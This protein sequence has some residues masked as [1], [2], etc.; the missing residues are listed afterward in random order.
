MSIH[1]VTITGGELL[2]DTGGAVG[3]Q[4]VLT[5][6]DCFLTANT[7][8]AGGAVRND[9]TMTI[10][11]TTVS[12]NSAVEYGGGIYNGG[13]ADLTVTGSTIVDNSA[14]QGA[15]LFNFVAGVLD[16][17][18]STIADND[19]SDQGGGVYTTYGTVTISDTTLSDNTAQQGGGIL[20]SAGPGEGTTVL[21]NTTVTRNSATLEGG[22]LYNNGCI[23]TLLQSTFSDNSATN[24][25]GGIYLN[26]G[27]LDCSSS[28]FSA[29]SANAA[30]GA[31]PATTDAAG[32]VTQSTFTG[33][34]AD[35]AGGIYA[36]SGTVEVTNTI[37]AGNTATTSNP[38]VGGSLT[39]LGNNLIGD[40]GTATGFTDGVN[41]DQVGSAGGVIDPMLGPLV[42]NGGPTLT[43][44]LLLGSPA[45]DA[46]NDA[47]APAT[48][49]R[50]MTR[51][52]DGDA[53]GT[54]TVDIGA[55]ELDISGVTFVV[56]S[57]ADTVDA[58]PGDGIAED[59]SGNTTLR[60]AIME[61][62]ALSG[63]DTITLPADMFRLS[64]T[65]TG[66]DAAATGDLDVTEHLTIVGAG[67]DSTAVNARPS[68]PEA[69]IDR[70]FQ[71]SSGAHL[72][73]TGLTVRG[74]NATGFGS[75]G[76]GAGVFNDG[77][78]T[79]ADCT[80]TDNTAEFYGGALY[81]EEDG[82][83]HATATTLTGNAAVKG[84]GLYNISA[85][86]VAASTLDAN[87]ATT[88][89]E[90]SDGGGIYNTGQFNLARSTFSGNTAESEGGGMYQ[91]VTGST[92]IT[93]C[94]FADNA[95]DV[96][97]G[98]F[99]AQGEV[100]S[101]NTIVATNTATSSNPDVAGEFASLGYNLI[102][103]AGSAAG[104]THGTRGIL[105]DRR[106]VP[107]ILCWVS[108]RTTADRRGRTRSAR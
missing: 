9:G 49:Q 72:R 98:I 20:S 19:A 24:H 6:A 11:D 102:G 97:G 80:L 63:W 92:T 64:L 101:K 48:D 78:L 13:S 58:N 46:G 67:A 42:D 85:A 69:G 107:S 73:L 91:T 70:V 74:G 71:V 89:G 33:N 79:V 100:K 21:T 16:V 5:I 37:V 75:D 40:V 1:G 103:D 31:D 106:R 27:T 29:N 77:T 96:A 62:N 36:V 43:H 105:S 90:N 8:L 30:G 3:S 59:V 12:E 76:N 26:S 81:N 2:A 87:T 65:G 108:L 66:E 45:V 86:T 61:A 23:L 38:D 99:N 53:D 15:G 10:V 32:D 94:T 18:D 52:L 47:A 60:A 41:K 39:S 57:L 50:G 55:F 35:T 84:A 83:L 82:V 17:S 25:G 54:A 88:G 22:G 56:D 7:A 51:V 93:D 68:D 104:F 95:A 34:S 4:G 28:T 14:Y 44:A